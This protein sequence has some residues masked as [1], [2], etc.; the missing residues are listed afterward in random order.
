MRIARSLPASIFYGTASLLAISAL[1]SFGQTQGRLDS[2]GRGGILRAYSD[3]LGVLGVSSLS[4][5]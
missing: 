5:V 2:S 4:Q 3:F 1:V